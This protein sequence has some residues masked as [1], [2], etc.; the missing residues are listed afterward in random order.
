[1]TKLQLTIVINKFSSNAHILQEVR[2][3]RKIR[4]RPTYLNICHFHSHVGMGLNIN[5]EIAHEVYV[6]LP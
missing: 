4:L 6:K 5:F 2:I 1:M 3:E